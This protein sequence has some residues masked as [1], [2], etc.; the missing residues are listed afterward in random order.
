M[1]VEEE[2]LMCK[3]N[4]AGW[5]SAIQIEKAVAVPRFYRTRPPTSTPETR[6]EGAYLPPVSAVS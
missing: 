3:R 4:G 1:H 2:A 6:P 5:N